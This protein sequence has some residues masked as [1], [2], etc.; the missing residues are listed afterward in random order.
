MHARAILVLIL[1][2][3]LRS[4]ARAQGPVAK[5]VDALARQ[6]LKVWRVPGLALAIVK[7]D[8]IVYLQ[9]YGVRE[10]GKKDPVTS[11]TVFPLASCTKSFTALAL[12]MLVHDGKLIWDHPVR[13]HL[14]YF[15]L[16]DPLADR[17]VTLRDLLTHRTGVGSHDLL[18]YKSPWTLEERIRRTARLDLKYS[19]RSTFEYQTVF[20]GAAGEAAAKAAGVSWRDLMQQRIFDPLDMKNTRAIEP[21]PKDSLI[22]STPHRLGADGRPV[23]M[24]RY[25][26]TAADPAG[27]IHTSAADLA[28]YLRF[29]LGDGTWQGKRLISAESLAEPRM[30]QI[31]LR[32]GEAGRRLNPDTV[33]M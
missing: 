13:K 18:W 31:V 24:E 2:A 3:A 5:E 21:G 30:P 32:V 25:P 27:T 26:L 1:L 20:F 12:G 6:A 28:K 11:D 17:D 9:G 22:L 23:L 4:E 8:R 29:Q 15:H 14:P 19:F 16:S 7:D 33:Q 10:A